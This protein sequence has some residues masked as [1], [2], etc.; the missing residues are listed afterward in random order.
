[1]ADLSRYSSRPLDFM[2]RFIRRRWIAHAAILA[3]VLAAVICSVSA[4]YGVKFLVDALSEGIGEMRNVWSAFLMLVLLIAA[5][6]L[7][8][9][10]ASL[11]ANFSFVGVTGDLRRDL[12]SHLTRHAPSYFADRLPGTLASRVTATSNAV[13]ATENMFVWNILPPCAATVAAVAFVGAISVP[14][15]ATLTLVAGILMV[16]MFRMAAAGRP[17]HHDFADK[18]ASVDGQMVDVLS[19][20]PIVRAFCGWGREQHRFDSIVDQE[21]TA[22]RSS[23]LYLERLRILH[24]S[25]IVILTVG[26][27]Q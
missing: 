26:S 15:A 2:Y 21:M 16:A 9:R 18:T 1:M 23:L 11:I 19:N 27:R 5:D 6:N 22:R 8:W 12:F 25:V 3:C 17:L 13:F 14:I 4:Q 24:A 10:I 20:M 7:L